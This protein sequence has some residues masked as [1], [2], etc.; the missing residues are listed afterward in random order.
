MKEFKTL[1][2][3]YSLIHFVFLSGISEEKLVAILCLIGLSFVLLC[4]I[5][6][7]KMS[8]LRKDI[9]SVTVQMLSIIFYTE[10]LHKYFYAMDLTWK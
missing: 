3:G 7:T 5:I 10:V 1:D 9:R 4:S 6:V 2:A 8:L